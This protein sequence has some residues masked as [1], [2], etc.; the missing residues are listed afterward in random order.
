MILHER[1]R[2][3]VNGDDDRSDKCHFQSDIDHSILFNEIWVTKNHYQNA[4][5]QA[6]HR[7]TSVLCILSN[8]K[9]GDYFHTMMSIIISICDRTYVCFTFRRSQIIRTSK[10]ISLIDC[11]WFLDAW[12]KRIA[13]I[14]TTRRK[15]CFDK[16][17]RYCF[18]VI[19]Q[20]GFLYAHTSSSRSIINFSSVSE[21]LRLSRHII[22]KE[23]SLSSSN[24]K[25][26]SSR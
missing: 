17:D 6:F 9:H 21:R 3:C 19:S 20:F 10:Y 1:V 7:W 4:S 23:F 12:S 14:N 26:W 5:N 11:N 8:K 25:Y 16:A 22:S 13:W 18:T 15:L 2:E 24:K